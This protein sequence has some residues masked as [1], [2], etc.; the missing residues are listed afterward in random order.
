MIADAVNGITIAMAVF[1]FAYIGQ[2]CAYMIE[3][4]IMYIN[5][6]KHEKDYSDNYYRR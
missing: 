6:E 3:T 2:A 4:T 5:M 1:A